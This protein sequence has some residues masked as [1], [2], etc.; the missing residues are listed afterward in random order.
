VP[1]TKNLVILMAD[2]L[3][4]DYF[5]KLPGTTVETIA[6]GTNTPTNLPAILC[7]VLPSQHGVYFFQQAMPGAG[8]R[9][10]GRQKMACQV[11]SIFDLEQLGYDVSYFDHPHDP[12]YKVLNNP[13]RKEL[14]KLKEPFI[15]V[16]RET[17]THVI[18]GRNWRLENVKV[19]DSK[20]GR[21]YYDMRGRDYIQA[22]KRREG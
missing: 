12:M 16:E 6:Q 22:H 21:A 18:Y 3:R 20:N 4:R 13:P 2:A 14:K 5:P 10:D 11:P 15:Y 8:V 19:E 9:R 7:G 1:I 17:A